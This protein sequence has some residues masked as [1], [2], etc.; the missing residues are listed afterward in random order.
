MKTSI[1]QEEYRRLRA[2]L[3]A[4]RDRFVIIR[5]LIDTHYGDRSDQAS[6]TEQIVHSIERLETELSR[7][8]E[9][10]PEKTRSASGR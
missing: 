8:D 2:E 1:P 9:S 7:F 10:P 4:A 3:T 5:E 6:R